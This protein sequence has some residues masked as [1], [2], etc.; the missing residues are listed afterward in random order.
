MLMELSIA[1]SF[2]FRQKYFLKTALDS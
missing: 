2:F 1:I